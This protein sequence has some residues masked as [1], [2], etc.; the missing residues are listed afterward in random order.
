M[1][2]VKMKKLRL[3]GLISERDDFLNGLMPLGCLEVTETSDA[4]DEEGFS[5]LH[6]SST[7][8]SGFR[9]INAKLATAIANLQKHAPA[10]GGLMVKRKDISAEEFFSS[11]IWR[12]AVDCAGEINRLV[13]E[14]GKHQATVTRQKS[15]RETLVPWQDLSIPLQAGE[16]EHACV[17]F[18]VMPAGLSLDELTAKLRETTDMAEICPASSDKEQHYF[19]MIC[20]KSVREEALAVLRDYGYGAVAFK[21]MTGTAAENIKRIDDEIKAEED[22]VNRCDEAIKAY[23]PKREILR[24]CYDRSVQEIAREQAKEKLMSTDNVYSL[25]GW[26]RADRIEE[27]EKLAGEFTCAWEM[28]D[29]SKEDDVPVTL[30]NKKWIAPVSMVTEMYS[31]PSYWGVDPNPLIYPFFIFF[32]GF[33]FA[34]IAYGLIL[35]VASL[36]IKK[37]Y[38][39]KKT[40]GQM[41]DLGIL[42]GLSTFICGV[43][44]GA[45]FGDALPVIAENFFGVKD[46]KLW[47]IISPLDDPM[48]ILYFGIAIGCFQMA[49]GQI[50]HICM[51][52]RDGAKAGIDAALDVIPW[53]V[54]F[55]GVAMIVLGKGTTWIIIGVA[56]LILTQGRHSKG[57]LRKFFGG[58]KS[59]YDTT[60]WLGDILSYSRLMAL[61]L[62][63]TV[64]ASVVNILGSLPGSIIA[65]IPIFLFG[66]CFNVGINVIG[67]YVHAARLQYLEYF[68][69]FYVSGGR[70]FQPL[71]YDTKYVDIVPDDPGKTA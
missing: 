12:D 56:C 63:T 5:L 14:I 10:K 45:C 17:Y 13:T 37:V 32:Y 15:V 49:V 31:L 34:D 58:V 20:H 48:T 39:P 25:E 8:L 69:K 50:I 9:G 28:E 22:E 64:I 35:F 27:F 71:S 30:K 19:A 3:L 57:I 42:I 54:F 67:T 53:W 47:S 16:S 66:H 18:A 23:A 11:D 43:L 46:F 65:F 51:G 4:P 55:V 6:K 33:M 21:G 41:F 60:S 44:T 2:I 59:L 24:V 38:K 36:I 68:S 40:M 1:S 52:F 62:A 29:P 26:L 61:M 70:P 7:D